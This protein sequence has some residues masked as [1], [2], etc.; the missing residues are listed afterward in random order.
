MKKHPLE[1]V[2]LE[3]CPVQIYHFYNETSKSCIYDESPE[4]KMYYKYCP[5][6]IEIDGLDGLL[7]SQSMN[8][9][10][11][12]NVIIRNISES[13]TVDIEARLF[14]IFKKLG[15]IRHC[16]LIENSPGISSLHFMPYLGEIRGNCKSFNY[17]D[18]STVILGNENLHHFFMQGFKSKRG[19][20]LV[21]NNSALCQDQIDMF[22]KQSDIKKGSSLQTSACDIS[23][24]KFNVLPSYETALFHMDKLE[25][26]VD[27]NLVNVEAYNESSKIE[28]KL[29]NDSLELALNA[30]TSYNAVITYKAKGDVNFKFNSSLK[31]FR[32]RAFEG[33]LNITNIRVTSDSSNIQWANLNNLENAFYLV[34]IKRAQPATQIKNGWDRKFFT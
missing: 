11:V 32:T 18:Y 16:L 20:V 19:A 22:M 24:I 17:S 33:F 7:S 28:V 14:D 31:S 4:R 9:T 27:Y 5:E 21:Q 15:D 23:V 34:V 26:G 30:N 10:M 6:S 12:S 8:C 2:C 25:D 13:S 3:R 1:N 29:L